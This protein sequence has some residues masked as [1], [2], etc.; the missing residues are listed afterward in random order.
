MLSSKMGVG[1]NFCTRIKFLSGEENEK[2]CFLG[3]ENIPTLEA[4]FNGSSI[5]IFSSW[6]KNKPKHKNIRR[7]D[8]IK[9]EIKGK[10]INSEAN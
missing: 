4:V 1:Y 3:F 10:L 8:E 9:I 5:F 6:A 2:S 7:C